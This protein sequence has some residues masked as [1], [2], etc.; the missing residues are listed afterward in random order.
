[1]T[2]DSQP[3]WVKTELA[4]VEAATALGQVEKA[5]ALRALAARYDTR[6]K[7]IVIDL[8]NGSSFSFPPQLAQGLG[9]AGPA[10]LAQIEISPHGVGLH[11]PKLDTDLTVEGLLSG[12]FGSRSWLRQHAAKAG[13]VRSQ[14]KTQAAK[15]N[16]TKG[17]RP[18]KHNAASA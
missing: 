3:D 2:K 13:S 9:N 7:C 10:E 16:G 11:W 12:L 17:G 1:M 4:R 14:A 6:K 8:T 15:A 5:G 18:R